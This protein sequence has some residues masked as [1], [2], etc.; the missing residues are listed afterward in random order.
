LSAADIIFI[1]NAD[2][3]VRST[4]NKDKKKNT[5]GRTI[6]RYGIHKRKDGATY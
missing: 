1:V 5:T 6:R 2:M 3:N 4:H